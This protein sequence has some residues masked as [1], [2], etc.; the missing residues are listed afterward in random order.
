M[1]SEQGMMDVFDL[2][3]EVDEAVEYHARTGR[4]PVTLKDDVYRDR[5][6]LAAISAL[7]SRLDA[8]EKRLEEIKEHAD[9]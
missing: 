9:E 1:E 6:I 5:D 4:Y 2:S 8:H 3:R 7:K